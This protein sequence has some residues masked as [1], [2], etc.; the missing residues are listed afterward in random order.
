VD[1]I[2]YKVIAVIL[3]FPWVLVGL[4]LLGSLQAWRNG[5]RRSA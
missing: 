5:T 2:Y 4:T 3:L 1:G